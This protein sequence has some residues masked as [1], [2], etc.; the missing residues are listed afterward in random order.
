MKDMEQTH[1]SAK[2]VDAQQNEDKTVLI[3][4]QTIFYPQGGGQPY[5]IGVI[6]S[7]DRFLYFKS[8]KC[9]MLKEWFIILE[10]LKMAC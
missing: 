2:I 8:K 5:D 9:A 3:L 1:C 10:L 4:D 7:V 6:K